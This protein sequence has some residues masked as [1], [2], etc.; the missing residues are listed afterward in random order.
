[1]TKSADLSRRNF[2]TRLALGIG[3]A[4]LLATQDKLQL[5]QS[6]MAASSSVGTTSTHKSLVC[7]FLY[8]G[9]DAFNMLIPYSQSAYQRYVTDRSV[10]A[11]P[12]DQLLPL[13]NTQQAFHPAMSRLQQLFNQGDLAVIANTGALIQPV[14]KTEITQ[15]T[16]VLPSDLFSHNHQ[17]EFWQTGAA[18]KA[19]KHAPG[20][21]GRMADLLVSA[22]DDPTTPALFTMA[23]N[24]LWQSG[25][26]PL[27][28]SVNPYQGILTFNHLRTGDWPRYRN[29][30]V[31]AWQQLLERRDESV[32]RNLLRNTYQQTTARVDKL[33]ALVQGTPELTT[34][35]N[36]QNH[37]AQQLRTVAT[38]IAAREAMGLKRQLFFVS[39]GGYDTHGDQLRSHASVLGALDEAL[40]SF[41]QTTIELGVA[42]S[43]TTFTA[44]EFGRT[45]T[46]NHDGSDH[47]WSGH[48][49]VMGADVKGGQV[50]GELPDFTL[51]GPDDADGN[52][53]F[54]PRYAMDQYAATLANWMGLSPS[55]QAEILPNLVN[56][57]QKNLGFM[58]S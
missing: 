10:M 12:Y 13:K 55:E 23:G 31:D 57:D 8:G 19:S 36:E 37:L 22:N 38:L 45:Y 28:F 40:S 15:E 7:V 11:L 2:L 21:G 9:N 33:N 18:A 14:T 49:L 16:A 26:Q 27:S 20:W 17:Q 4:S 6:A 54:I 24:S 56:F 29:S 43:V 52:G 3:G 58:N 1:M 53:R 35:Y 44:S 48:Q 46:S 30:R 39:A 32:F 51:G 50:H 5:I 25:L 42:D 47:G 34:P 41:Y